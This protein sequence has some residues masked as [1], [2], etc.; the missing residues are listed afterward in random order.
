MTYLKV[1]GHL[2]LVRDETTNAILNTNMSDYNNYM[3][4]KKIKE[5]DSK[6][7]ENLESDMDS[8]KSDLEEI[9]NLLRNLSN[10]SK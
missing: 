3:R 5:N 4:L 8:I 10:G 7:V 2:H 1:E 6:R 9:K